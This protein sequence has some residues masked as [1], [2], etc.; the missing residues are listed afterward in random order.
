MFKPRSQN[1]ITWSHIDIINAEK[2][3][4]EKEAFSAEETSP[5]VMADRCA[6][7]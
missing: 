7:V 2:G 5:C 4:K 3:Y 1:S 6:S